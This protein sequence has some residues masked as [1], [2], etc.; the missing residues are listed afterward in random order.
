MRVGSVIAADE[1]RRAAATENGLPRQ[2][3]FI[4]SSS[5]SQPILMGLD[6]LD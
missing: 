2:S 1:A 5:V 3:F 4:F 6:P